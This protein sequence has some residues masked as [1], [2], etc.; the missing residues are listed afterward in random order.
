MSADPALLGVAAL[1]ASALQ[2]CGIRYSIGGSMASTLQGEPRATL[3]IDV[4]VDLSVAMVPA[5]LDALGSDFYAEADSLQRAALTRGSVNVYHRPTSVKVDLFVAGDS[6][7][8]QSQ[9][10][11]RVAV[12]LATGQVFVHTAEDILLQKLHWYRLGGEV[13]DRQWR[14]ILGV[15]RVQGRRLDLAFLKA[16]AQ[17]A[18]VA[19]LLTKALAE[20]T[21]GT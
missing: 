7:L 3:D 17:R 16:M 5:L 15:L 8:D 12:D 13:S 1:V 4:L 10:E 18:G 11:R 2:R 9:L 14:D 20:Q 19:D 21:P 6:V